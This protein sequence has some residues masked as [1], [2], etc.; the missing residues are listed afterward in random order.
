M[1]SPTLDLERWAAREEQEAWPQ[2]RRLFFETAERSH[3]GPCVEARPQRLPRRRLV[4]SRLR[5]AT[6]TA[7]VSPALPNLHPEHPS[8]ATREAVRVALIPNPNAPI[9]FKREQPLALPRVI[10]ACSHQLPRG[11]RNVRSPAVPRA[12]SLRPLAA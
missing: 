9:E 6:A 11:V 2:T 5:G 1:R 4:Q 8:V 12:G 3:L 7:L 10:A